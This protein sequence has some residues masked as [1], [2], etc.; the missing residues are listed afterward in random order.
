VADDD[1]GGW[2]H[3]VMLA[4]GH[5]LS[6]FYATIFTPL[7]ETFRV[8][9]GLTVAGI[10][11]VGAIIGIFGSMMQ[12]VFGILS[13]RADRR[14]LAAG[15]MLVSAVFI[16]LIGL[17]TSVY[18]LAALL[19]LG[20][21]G[22][23]AFHP[24]GAVL[25]TRSDEARHRSVAFFIAGGGV[26][27][28]IAPLAV[29]AIVGGPGDLPR[30][31]PLML[32]GI[33]LS[34]WLLL[35]GRREA[36]APAL[37][38]ALDLRALFAQGTR[39]VWA[40]F[41]MATVRSI[42]FVAFTFNLTILGSARDWSQVKSRCVLALF[43]GCCVVGSLIGGERAHRGNARGL[44][45]VSCIA[46]APFLFLFALAQG[47][48]SIAAFALAG[49]LAG[50]GT[51]VN[52][53]FAQELRPQSASTVSGLMMGMAWGVASV[54]LPVVGVLADR[55]GVGATLQLVA[56]LHALAGGFVVF[57]PSGRRSGG[58]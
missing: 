12:P 15:G 36:R 4:A 49:L 57:L 41:G 50:M 56:W 51:P 20:A 17:S 22:V 14:A 23:A 33:A 48:L 46:T 6:D 16:P 40:L 5:A 34:A 1:R 58:D 38:R 29:A 37:G 10:S 55:M 39:P 53:S 45:A 21:L 47:W 13:D 32:P 8:A 24:S 2:Q 44:L 3:V 26:G 28:V 27:L 19:T 9:F 54:L 52:I 42:V 11:T 25:A 7:V 30:L 31:W 35:A 18:M 43:L